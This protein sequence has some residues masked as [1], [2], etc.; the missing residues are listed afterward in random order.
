MVRCDL[1][2]DSPI[3][4][5]YDQ[6]Y[7]VVMSSLCIEAVARSH[8]EY[9]QGMKKLANLIKPGGTL[10]IFGHGELPGEDGFYVVGEEKFRGFGVAQDAALEA[11]KALVSLSL[12]PL[13]LILW[14]DHA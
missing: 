10:L 7:D 6:Q 9:T 2:Q 4:K 12:H 13:Y 5:G 1:T 14:L 3:D 8:E 11:V